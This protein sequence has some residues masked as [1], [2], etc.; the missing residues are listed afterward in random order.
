MTG[1]VT[2]G[3]LPLEDAILVET[4]EPTTRYVVCSIKDEN[5]TKAEGQISV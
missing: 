1:N 4:K 5:V 2:C 3:G